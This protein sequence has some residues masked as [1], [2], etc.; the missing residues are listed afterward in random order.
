[1]TNGGMQWIAGGSME[2]WGGRCVQFEEPF[3]AGSIWDHPGVVVWAESE[4]RSMLVV[5]QRSGC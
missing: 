3:S 4:M 1:M 2:R 5:S